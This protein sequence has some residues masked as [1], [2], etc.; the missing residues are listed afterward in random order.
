MYQMYIQIH[1]HSPKVHSIL[2]SFYY[3]RAEFYLDLCVCVLNNSTHTH[4]ITVTYSLQVL[5]RNSNSLNIHTH[6]YLMYANVDLATNQQ[7]NNNK[8]RVF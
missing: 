4:R 2:K 8:K 6:I 5:I 1:A 7:S 3:N